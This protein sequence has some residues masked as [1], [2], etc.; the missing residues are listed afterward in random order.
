LAAHFLYDES[1]APG[2]RA[3]GSQ[4]CGGVEK[5]D[6]WPATKAAMLFFILDPRSNLFLGKFPHE[7]D[8]GFAQAFK[9]GKGDLLK[10]SRSAASTATS[11][12]ATVLILGNLSNH[13]FFA[14]QEI[15]RRKKTGS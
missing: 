12:S 5:K 3:T 2:S 13:P 11:I 7:G 8:L 9:H 14:S 1:L 4:N 15:A 10:F 6:H